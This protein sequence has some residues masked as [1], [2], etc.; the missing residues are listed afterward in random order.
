[1]LVT[2]ERH[3]HVMLLK[4]H[5]PWASVFAQEYAGFLTEPQA[6]N[7]VRQNNSM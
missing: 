7:H 3:Y 2:I 5:Q 4:Y 1:M 6:T